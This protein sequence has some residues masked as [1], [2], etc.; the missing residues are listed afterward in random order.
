MSHY[1]SCR[2]HRH[3]MP[4]ESDPSVRRHR[5]Q[6]EGVVRLQDLL[7]AE[8]PEPETGDAA[9]REGVQEI[10]GR[11]D[12]TEPTRFGDWEKNGRCIDF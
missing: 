4:N 11:R 9:P 3:I 6:A 2:I 1:Q 10:G 8:Q 7:D 12:G 5:P